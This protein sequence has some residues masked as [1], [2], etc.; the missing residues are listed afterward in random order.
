M[1]TGIAYACVAWTHCKDI[2]LQRR[3]LTRDVG[4]HVVVDCVNNNVAHSRDER[5]KTNQHGDN[6]ADP[7]RH[8]PHGVHVLL[9][10]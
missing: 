9:D 3:P 4:K 2:A 6:N 1:Y 7:V 10:L 5:C 8:L